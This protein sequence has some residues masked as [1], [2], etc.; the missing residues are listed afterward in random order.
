MRTIRL[1]ESEFVM[2]VKS[3]PPAP[4]LAH[5]KSQ[6]KDLLKLHAAR[7]PQVAQRIREFHPRFREAV[8]TAIFAAPLRLHDAQLT[9]ARERGFSTWARLKSHIEKPVAAD[10]RRLPHHERIADPLFRQALDF[11]DRGDVARLRVLLIQHPALISQRVA[12]EGEN[13]FRNPTLLEFVAENPV[14][15]GTLPPNIVE[16]ATLLLDAGAK[17]DFP[18]LNETLALVSSGCVA[19]EGNLQLPLIDVLCR[20]G[21]DPNLALAVALPHAEFD[22][23]HAL[24]RNGA[25]LDLPAAAALGRLDDSRR[26]LPAATPQ[27]RHRALALASQFG[28]APVVALLLDSGEDPN[29]YNPAGTHSHSTPLHQAAA[30]SHLD[31]VR[32]LVERGAVL[33]LKDTLWQGTPAD[34]AKHEGHSDIERYL[35]ARQKPDTGP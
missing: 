32:L 5:F 8:D 21:A 22:A 1:L 16:I 12:F 20:Y 7:D 25:R 35:R 9:I 29:R 11:L 2:P 18:A 19:R 15:R 14:R 10:D 3:L 27:D 33:D 28:H 26:L 31:V 34:W 17:H 30:G 23:V 4:D 6:A 24:L 13:Y